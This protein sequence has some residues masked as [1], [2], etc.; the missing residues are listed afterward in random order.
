MRDCPSAIE[1]LLFCCKIKA[2]KSITD[3]G[4]FVFANCQKDIKKD[5]ASFKSKSETTKQFA[6]GNIIFY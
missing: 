1:R 5:D 4:A 3:L 6:W 2:L